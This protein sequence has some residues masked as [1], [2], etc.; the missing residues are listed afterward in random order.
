M[1]TCETALTPFGTNVLATPAAGEH[2][3][4]APAAGRDPPGGA[5]GGELEAAEAGDLGGQHPRRERVLGAQPPRDEV[6]LDVV[7]VQDVDAHV[8]R[9]VDRHLREVD[10][11]DVGAAD[12]DGE[13]VVDRGAR[14]TC[15]RTATPSGPPR[16]WAGEPATS[17]TRTCPGSTSRHPGQ[18]S[19]PTTW[20][21]S[22]TCA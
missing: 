7:Q 4:V 3:L 20:T 17:C 15:R 13:Q 6:G 19:K 14:T 22:K 11:H 1:G 12:A 9:H 5:G 16:A 18:E 21:S 10:V 2:L 8:A